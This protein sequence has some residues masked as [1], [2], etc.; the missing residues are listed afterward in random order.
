M[1]ALTEAQRLSTAHHHEL[2]NATLVSGA[3]VGSI[4]GMIGGPVGFAAGGFVGALVGALGGVVLERETSRADAHDR[5]LDF[6]TG[7]TD[8]DLDAHDVAAA[9][10]TRA[11]ER[12]AVERAR[13]ERVLLALDETTTSHGP[14]HHARWSAQ[15]STNANARR[16]PAL[17]PP[18]KGAAARMR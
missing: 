8:H 7:V 10:L 1:K 16:A 18:T 6:E 15:P 5:D 3:V 14:H 12:A 2:R 9:G 17:R 4:L 11:E 13:T